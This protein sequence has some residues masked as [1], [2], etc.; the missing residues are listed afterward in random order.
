M[1]GQQITVASA[2]RLAARLVASHGQTLDVPQLGLG[3][4]FPSAAVLAKADLTSL[5]M[6]KARAATLS[7]VAAAVLKNPELLGASCE[8]DEA[9][10]RL[11]AIPGVGEWTAQY[12]ALRQLREPDAFPASD[13][14][15][16][17]ALADARGKRPSSSELLLRAERW[18]PGA[19][20]PRST[21]GPPEPRS[22]PDR[23]RV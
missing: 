3:R 23:G 6:P 14:G 11:R 10:Q 7:A 1:L 12:I 4:C 2:V 8:L 16:M 18:R 19:P 5:G 20:T 13:I 22:A 21:C 17:R 15:L 9:V